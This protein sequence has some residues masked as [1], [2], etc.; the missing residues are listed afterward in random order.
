MAYH[1]AA[2]EAVL[3]AAAVALLAVI[4]MRSRSRLSRNTIGAVAILCG[5]VGAGALVISLGV[6]HLVSSLGSAACAPAVVVKPTAVVGDALF[7]AQ[8]TYP[9]ATTVDVQFTPAHCAQGR[10]VS[11]PV[12]VGSSLIETATVPDSPDT[13][14]RW[15]SDEM[16]AAGWSIRTTQKDA[17]GTMSFERNG[18]VLFVGA[19][20]HWRLNGP[21]QPPCCLDLTVPTRIYTMLTRSP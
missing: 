16:A 6:G 17:S 9:N 14:L 10:F 2:V 12:R 18:D 19:D 21:Q 3:L 7:P 20:A 5:V 11:H 1:A 4:A 8:L 13:I 15:Y